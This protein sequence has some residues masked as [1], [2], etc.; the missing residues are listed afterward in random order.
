MSPIPPC[1]RPDAASPVAVPDYKKDRQSDTIVAKFQMEQQYLY[2][3]FFSWLKTEMC[4]ELDLLQKS[5]VQQESLN[6]LFLAIDGKMPLCFLDSLEEALLEENTER[7][8]PLKRIAAA[9]LTLYQAQKIHANVLGLLEGEAPMEKVESRLRIIPKELQS[10][11]IK[12]IAVRQVVA[13]YVCKSLTPFSGVNLPNQ[14][15]SIHLLQRPSITFLRMASPEKVPKKLQLTRT[16]CAM[17]ES[18][19]EKNFRHIDLCLVKLKE[20][21]E[22][23][24]AAC[25]RFHA[26]EMFPNTLTTVCADVYSY[27]IRQR[28]VYKQASRPAKSFLSEWMTHLFQSKLAA[29][30]LPQSWVE[31]RGVHDD[32]HALL[33]HLWADLFAQKEMLDFEERRDFSIMALVVMIEYLCDKIGPRT[34]MASCRAH[35]DR[36][37]LVSTALYLY[38]L[39]KTGQKEEEFFSRLETMIFCPAIFAEGRPPWK[40]RVDRLLS[41]MSRLEQP[42]IAARFFARKTLFSSGICVLAQ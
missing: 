6:N 25:C 19:K 27:F 2:E 15:F 41:L 1:K 8:E 22:E 20:G 33:H 17:L 36:G 39:I 9:V 18:Y 28:G 5:V 26:Q 24:D 38:I 31:D 10:P 16:Y 4:A 3:N 29:F 12:Q 23:R 13:S 7:K 42:E 40:G 14:L 21:S 37:M 34:V 35:I 11:R 30:F 32:A